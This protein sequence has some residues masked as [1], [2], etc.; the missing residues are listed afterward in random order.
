MNC[1]RLG[2]LKRT[3]QQSIKKPAISAG[4][5][6]A[7]PKN[8]CGGSMAWQ[9]IPFIFDKFEKTLSSTSP[10]SHVV[11]DKIPTVIVDSSF[12]WDAVLA[13]GIAGLIPGAIAYIA[14]KNSNSLAEMQL[15]VQSKTKIDDEIRVA[16]ANYVTAIN[17]LA[18]DYSA[19]VKEVMDRK[20]SVISKEAMPEHLRDNIYRAES[21]KN[22]LTLLI[23][24]DEEGN[25]LLKDMG[26]AQRA[27]DPLLEANATTKDLSQLRIS[28]NN[29]MFS[30][31]EYFKRS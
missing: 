24:P 31:H 2:T 28:V 27:L 14:L 4:F 19:W 10:F 7:I 26:K 20:I 6:Y 1:G 30:C 21:N 13:A 23:T 16:A 29:F 8:N 9:G 11:L 12:S 18:I 17:Y 3:E 15:R 25:K 5:C 22:L